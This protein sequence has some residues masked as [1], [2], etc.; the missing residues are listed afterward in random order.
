MDE[1][2]EAV[3]SWPGVGLV[4]VVFG[5]A[6]GFCLRL[7]VLAYPRGDPRRAELIAELY[8]VPRIQRPL[9]VAEQLEVALFEGLGHRVSAAIRRL[10]GRRRARPQTDE[11]GAGPPERST[12][13]PAGFIALY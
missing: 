1:L 13:E 10:T 8:A 5:F 2:L 7:I 12:Q 11:H 3:A 4:V 9:W 6:P